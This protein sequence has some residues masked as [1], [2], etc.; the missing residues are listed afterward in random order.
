MEDDFP[1]ST[2]VERS[3]VIQNGGAKSCHNLLQGRRSWLDR[4]TSQNIR[5][6]DVCPQRTQELRHGAFSCTDTTGQR[7]DSHTKPRAEKNERGPTRGRSAL[8]TPT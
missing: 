1:Q 6:D 2:P 4:L 3:G 8:M 5:I 7:N